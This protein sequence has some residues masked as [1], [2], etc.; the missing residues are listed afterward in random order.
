M[1]SPKPNTPKKRANTTNNTTFL[2]SE[3]LNNLLNPFKDTFD[4]GVSRLYRSNP[5][6]FVIVDDIVA[7]PMLHGEMKT[8]IKVDQL[9]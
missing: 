9:K 5:D 8:Q 7:T 2:S 4:L 1:T 6:L 3:E